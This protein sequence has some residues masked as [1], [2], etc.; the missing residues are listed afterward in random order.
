[1]KKQL[2]IFSF[3]FA[4]ASFQ[5]SNATVDTLSFY[6]E[7][8]EKA[9]WELLEKT[10]ITDIAQSKASTW[11]H[12]SGAVLASMMVGSGYQY[13]QTSSTESSS[14]IKEML[15][16]KNVYGAATCAATAIF[17]VQTL[18]CYLSNQA[19]RTAV[20]NFFANYE[21]NKYFVPAQ[22]ENAF[23]M[24]AERIELEGMDAVLVDANDIVDQVQGMI[25]RYFEKRYEKVLQGAAYNALADAKTTGEIIKN[26]VETGS[27]LSGGK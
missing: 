23:D 21:E 19:N 16:P 26:A 11:N 6:D 2:Q 20:A 27:K 10:F 8:Q 24:I 22:L 5:T 25:M 17:A 3:I 1:M 7:F 9:Q 15:Q 4:I 12:I 13:T 14:I 18:Q